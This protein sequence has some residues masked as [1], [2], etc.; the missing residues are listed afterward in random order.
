MQNSAYHSGTSTRHAGNISGR[1][2]A[3]QRMYPPVSSSLFLPRVPAW[4]CGRQ[5]GRARRRPKSA[6]RKNPIRLSGSSRDGWTSYP[7]S[8]PRNQGWGGLWYIPTPCC[9]GL[10]ATSSRQISHQQQRSGEGDSSAGHR[11]A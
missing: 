3:M 5:S 9:H 7:I 8:S 10:A 1:T 6:V 4:R 11:Q 2:S